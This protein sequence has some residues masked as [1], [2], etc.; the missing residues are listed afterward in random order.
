MIDNKVVLVEILEKLIWTWELAKS[1]RDYFSYKETITNQ[2]INWVLILL[3]ESV[4]TITNKKKTNT[5][6]KNISKLQTL[7]QKEMLEKHS[8]DADAILK[9][10]YA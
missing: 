10:L 1:L 4:K 9:Q 5:M 2:D 3:K 8:E 7:Y 6:L